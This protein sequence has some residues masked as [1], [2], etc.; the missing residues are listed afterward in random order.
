MTTSTGWPRIGP[1]T[2]RT[3]TQED[4]LRREASPQVEGHLTASLQVAKSA[5]RT[6]SRWRHGFEPRWDYKRKAP[7]QGTS[8]KSSGSPHVRGPAVRQYAEPQ[9]LAAGLCDPCAYLHRGHRS[10][11]RERG[12]GPLPRQRHVARAHV[13]WRMTSQSDDPPIHAVRGGRRLA[14]EASVLQAVVGEDTGRSSLQL[15]G[16]RG[17]RVR[18]ESLPAV[19]L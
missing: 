9:A 3:A 13:R 10:L 12:T 17:G 1:A 4:G 16:A 11:P 5:L 19:A 2:H 14:T 6:L 18:S 8:S 15:S 7:G